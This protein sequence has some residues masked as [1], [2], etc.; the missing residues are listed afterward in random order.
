MISY[1]KY[2]KKIRNTN[3]RNSRKMKD[4]HKQDSKESRHEISIKDKKKLKTSEQIDMIIYKNTLT[5]TL[6]I[7]N[8]LEKSKMKQKEME[9]KRTLQKNKKFNTVNFYQN[10]ED[11]DFDRFKHFNRKKMKNLNN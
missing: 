7:L 1:E 6:R 10:E 5:S 9:L 11:K 8:V 4:N 3:E 2:T